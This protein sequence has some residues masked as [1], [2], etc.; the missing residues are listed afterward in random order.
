MSDIENSLTE[1]KLNWALIAPGVMHLLG[2]TYEITW[3][4][5]GPIDLHWRGNRIH[6][7]WSIDSAVTFAREHMTMLL[8]M[9][10]EP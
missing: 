5:I 2:T 8:E 6:F 10:L 4:G 1:P 9:G 3:N 7:G